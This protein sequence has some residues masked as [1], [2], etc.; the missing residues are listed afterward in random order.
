[1]VAEKILEAGEEMPRRW[2]ISGTSGYD[3]LAAM[4]A[5]WVSPAGEAPLTRFYREFTGVEDTYEEIVL[6]AKRDI[7]QN[8]LASEVHMLAHAL[9]QIAEQ[10]RR[11]RDFTLASLVRV[12]EE[13]VAAF[14]VY[15][16]YVRPD[17]A[18]EEHDEAHIRR[19]I[20]AARRR[21]PMIDRSLFDFLRRVLLVEDR[22]EP[23]VRFAMRFQ[24]LTG[25]V[26]AKGVEDT[27]TYRFHP[28]ASLNE[29]GC[30]AGRF[31]ATT[32]S[33]HAHSSAA[34]ARW[35][36]SMTAATTHDTKRSEDVRARIAVL[37]EMPAEWESA[38]RRLH[39]LASPHRGDLDG[40]PAPS[41][42]AAY[43]FYQTLVGAMP[44]AGPGV[45]GELRRRM[46]EYMVKAARE[47]KQRTSWMIPDEAY[48]R[49]LEAFVDGALQDP[50][51]VEAASR[52]AATVA[53]FGAVN[54][55]AQLAVRLAS[56]GIPDI[57]QGT[58]LWELSLVDPDNRRAVD[59]EARRAAA[60]ELDRRGGPSPELV[61]DLASSF[62]DGLV[63]LHVMRTCLRAR[64]ARPELFLEGSYQPLEGG[65]H[66]VAFERKHG[67]LRHV[68][69]A[70]RLVRT[71]VGDT[72]PWSIG[73]ALGDAELRLAS[74]GAFRDAFTGTYITGDTLRLGEVLRAFPVAWLTATEG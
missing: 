46:R 72:D 73:G 48:E 51:F 11:A 65:E 42:N 50:A 55:I 40:E 15:G 7:V 35:L 5:V 52:F 22:T 27:A 68:C 18:R 16:T 17:G 34:L 31:A 49:A 57:Y 38:V 71:L 69:V 2:T 25:P 61:R 59:Y 6:Q 26:M 74:A 3:F 62:A 28:L 70:P 29:V 45:D 64:R 41:A 47:A 10:N 12:L 56:P 67:D 60:A 30:D 4:N 58:E 13:T 14:P 63:K 33:L 53:P 66:V 9:K 43:L 19:A 36:L 8:S 37:S 24:Q 32:A 44:L 1:V 54:S 21:T 23:V 39:E 20:R